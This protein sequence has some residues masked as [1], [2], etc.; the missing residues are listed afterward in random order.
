MP[1]LATRPVRL[2]GLA[3]ALDRSAPRPADV[4]AMPQSCL[5]TEWQAPDKELRR[6]E[7][8]VHRL[9]HGWHRGRHA[10]C[11]YRPSLAC[12]LRPR[13]LPRYRACTWG[14][15]GTGQVTLRVV[16]SSDAQS[17][18]RVRSTQRLQETCLPRPQAALSPLLTLPPE[19]VALAVALLKFLL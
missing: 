2:L 12:H 18:H 15:T 5:R 11:R 9:G 16:R 19:L 8:P 1:A 13:H 3:R 6:T 7:Q 10:S 17:G 14:R 4:P